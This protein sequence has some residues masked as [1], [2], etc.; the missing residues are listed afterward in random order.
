MAGDSCNQSGRSS[1]EE[2]DDEDVLG[3]SAARNQSGRSSW[4]S[5]G[6]ACQLPL[7]VLVS[8]LRSRSQSGVALSLLGA[9]LSSGGRSRSQSGILPLSDSGASNGWLLNS[10]S[11]EGISSL[12]APEA[13]SVGVE[14]SR[15]ASHGG[16][17]SLP[18]LAGGE[19]EISESHGGTWSS[20]APVP[21][22]VPE[23]GAW[24][25][26]FGASGMP[27]GRGGRGRP[28]SHGGRC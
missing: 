6:G 21:P 27:G 13:E 28:R 20:L 15:P 7:G 26:L 8:L 24:K 2:S 1:D 25:A 5:L 12:L 16:I 11:Q 18:A 9:L 19:E 17:S 22:N 4:V 10:W 14:E 23:L 3:E